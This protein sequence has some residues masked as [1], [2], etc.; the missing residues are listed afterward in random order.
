M[1]TEPQQDR[2][3]S[4]FIPAAGFGTRLRPLTLKNPKPLVPLAGSCALEQALLHCQ[5]HGLHKIAVNGHYLHKQIEA[6]C[7]DKAP[8]N[9]DVYFSRELEILGTLGAIQPLS[10]WLTTDQLLI[11]NGDIV[12]NIDLTKLIH[13]HQNNDCP[14]TLCGRSEVIPGENKLHVV[15]GLVH[16]IS[17]GESQ[18]SLAYA[19]AM[20][21]D[22]KFL[23]SRVKVPGCLIKDFCIPELTLG[24]RIAIME[25][26]GFWF[27]L[28]NPEELSRCENDLKTRLGT[29]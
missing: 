2:T 10:S 11:Y 18:K 26:H 28:R 19:C 7:R 3:T 22:R 17:K 1:N 25:H 5:E 27:D 14:I 23:S 21:V 9:L 12:S 16:S 29:N 15:D 6:F 4:V 8:E 20:V 24:T 13:H